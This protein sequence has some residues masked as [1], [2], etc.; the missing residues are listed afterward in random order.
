MSV[1]GGKMN[2]TMNAA[3]RKVRDDRIVRAFLA[4]LTYR[5]IAKA[6]DLRSTGTIHSIVERELADDGG[7]RELLAGQAPAVHLERREALFAAHWS[8]A[9]QREYRSSVICMRILDLQQRELERRQRA[10]EWVDPV[11]ADDVEDELEAWRRR[12]GR[13]HT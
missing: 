8:A 7:R 10:G 2:R 1:A 13:N 11:G 9:L 4:G 12:R 3:E 5:Q 6:F